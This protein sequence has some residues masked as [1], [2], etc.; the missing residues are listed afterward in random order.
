M[1]CP[2]WLWKTLF[3]RFWPSEFSHLCNA[4]GLTRISKDFPGITR[5]KDSP[6]FILSAG[7]R[8]GSTL[9]QRLINSNPKV[10]VWGEAYE[11][12]FTVYH[13]LAPLMR[14][15]KKPLNLVFLRKERI[16]S[17]DDLASI[18]T[19]TWIANLAPPITNLIMAHQAYFISLFK[20]PAA[21]LGR[22]RWGLKMV[23]GSMVVATY[24]KWLY[25]GAKILYL[26][27]NPYDAFKSYKKNAKRP[28]YL[29]YPSH[30]ISGV[31]PFVAHWRYCMDGFLESHKDLGAFMVSYESLINRQICS[32]LQEY[33]ELDLDLSILDIKVDGYSGYKRDNSRGLTFREKSIIKILA[34]NVALECGYKRPAD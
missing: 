32:Q 12:Y 11:D 21:N 31:I 29:Y 15:T 5:S 6:V 9:L 1:N 24:L 16:K 3:D 13:M 7:W 30:P 26:Y 10:M 27:R 14:F 28:W 8:S 22:P 4:Q 20:T 33:L 19:T 23:R 34:G 2:P 18:L 17:P 25:P